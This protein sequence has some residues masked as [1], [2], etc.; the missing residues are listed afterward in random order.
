MTMASD[1]SRELIRLREQELALQ[2]R[3]RAAL[4]A[5]SSTPVR[6]PRLGKADRRLPSGR[7]R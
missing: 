4:D 6:D 2:Q 7:T 3:I 5:Q 1:T